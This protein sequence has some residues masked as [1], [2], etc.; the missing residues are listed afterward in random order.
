MRCPF[1]KFFAI[2]NTVFAHFFVPTGI[3]IFYSLSVY[4]KYFFAH[5]L[6]TFLE[7]CNFYFT[8]KIF[9][10]RVVYPVLPADGLV[11]KYHQSY[12]ELL[13]YRTSARLTGR[14]WIPGICVAQRYFTARPVTG[15]IACSI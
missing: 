14:A 4:F 9:V 15:L 5:Y 2:F 13:A 1:V 6:R 12:K 3:C 11:I 7:V 8:R 10:E